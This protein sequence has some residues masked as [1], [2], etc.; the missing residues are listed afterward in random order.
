MSVK[1]VFA[2]TN[3]FDQ[4]GR[5]GICTCASMQW[6]RKTLE[7]KRGLGSFDELALTP[8]QMNGLMAQLRKL[9]ADPAG[10]S[11]M[12]GLEPVG[13][14]IAITTVADAIRHTSG[15]APNIAVFWTQ[16]HT[17]AVRCGKENEFF[18]IENGLWLASDA[19]ELRGK[20]RDVF[21]DGNYGPAI[22][23]RIVKLKS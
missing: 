23:M 12:M 1:Q 17:M 2:M 6:A 14:D 22:G 7:R 19:D 10:Q 4:G 5:V 18:D 13:A 8:H 20:M 15:T 16:S 11:D 21:R 3:N 9:D